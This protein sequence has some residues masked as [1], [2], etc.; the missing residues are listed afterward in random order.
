MWLASADSVAR[1]KGYVTLLSRWN[2]RINLVGRSDLEAVRQRHIVDCMQLVA[3]M[4]ANITRAVD[5]GA[6]A[7]L[8]GL[9]VAIATGAHVH[10]IERDQRKAAFLREAIRHTGAA[11]T[12]NAADFLALPSLCADVVLSRATAPLAAL[13]DAAH[14]HGRN[15]AVMLLHKSSNQ[16]AEINTAARRFDFAMQRIPSCSDARGEIWRVEGISPRAC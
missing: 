2:T 13:L 6:G 5:L 3:L 16:A 10:L 9:V 7:G 11:A 4:P 14:R 15:G 1:L 12:V 8:P